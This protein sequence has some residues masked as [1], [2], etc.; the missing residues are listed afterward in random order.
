MITLIPHTVRLVLLVCSSTVSA[1]SLKKSNQRFKR[2]S[3]VRL[4][5]GRSSLPAIVGCAQ[6]VRWP[7]AVPAP[8]PPP[9]PLLAPPASHSEPFTRPPSNRS[10]SSSGG[11]H[12]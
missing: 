10:S 3:L 12:V 5:A 6:S 8:P 11:G 9:P 1:N 2:G 4:L 7:G